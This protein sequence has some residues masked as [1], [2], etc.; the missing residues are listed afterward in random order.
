MCKGQCDVGRVSVCGSG[1]STGY[2]TCDEACVLPVGAS[3][4]VSRGT[5]ERPEYGDCRT[6][7]ECRAG[8]Y[9]RFRT[10]GQVECE[11][12]NDQWKPPY[13]LWAT[14]GL[15]VNDATSCLWECRKDIS[16]LN[17][18]RSGCVLLANRGQIPGN[19]AGWYGIKG[20]GQ[21]QTCG[22]GQG[23][24]SEAGTALVAGECLTCPAF[25]AL[26]SWVYN[27]QAC[28]WD[29]VSGVRRGGGCFVVP[30]DCRVRGYALDGLTGRCVRSPLPWS[31]SGQRKT[32]IAIETRSGGGWNG[33]GPTYLRT[34]SSLYG[35]AGRHVVLTPRRNWTVDGPICSMASAW[36]GGWEYMF[37]TVCNTSFLAYLNLSDPKARL[38]VLIG[39]PGVRG[40]R[41]GF[42]TEA[43]FQDEL[44]VAS[45]TENRTLFVLDR[46]NCLLREVVIADTPG[47]YLTRVYTVFGLTDKFATAGLARCY[48][49]GSLASPRKFWM[50]NE[51]RAIFSDDNGLWQLELGSREVVPALSETTEQFEA[52]E[53]VGVSAPDAYTLVLVFAQGTVW[54]VRANEEAC[55]DDWTS[56]DGGD[57]T[58][59]CVWGDGQYVNQSTGQCLACTGLACGV[60]KEWVPCTRTA[61]AYCGAC[62]TLEDGRVYASAGTCDPSLRKFVPPCPIG[63]YKASAWCEQC[64]RFST[65]VAG[66]AVRLE[67]CK[68]VAGFVRRAGLCVTDDPLYVFEPACAASCALP[69]NA[70]LVAVR[71]G[72]GKPC[73][74]ECNTGFYLDSLA[75]WMDK[76]R[77]CSKT[78]NSSLLP[79]GVYDSSLGCESA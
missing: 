35:V 23:K 63:F 74:W 79:N 67:Q 3:F 9:K 16:A 44:Y 25:P 50:L 1:F 53:L 56:L 24:T 69:G 8:H 7:I 12:C 5:H 52:D 2:V 48:G 72:R 13:A 28:E 18:S 32:G 76:C 14:E 77:P 10:N 43:L 55:P 22:V 75:P 47:S 20:S 45:G 59:P 38:G 19:T 31:R 40:W 26:A 30:A 49:L 21:H 60:G 37:G 70:T 78:A 61:Q 65:T 4:T 71:D 58:T 41:D 51:G 66:G 39:S 57:C 11:P 64:P 36:V 42:R 46:W 34:G 54:V 68:C 6:Y 27:G 62:P 33:S 15:S 29:C 73:A 17:A